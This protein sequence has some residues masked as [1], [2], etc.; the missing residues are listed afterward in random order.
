METKNEQEWFHKFYE[1]TF[2]IQGWKSRMNEILKGVPP[3]ERESVRGLLAVLGE[4]IGREWARDNKVRRIDTL[5]LQ[6]WGEELQRAKKR[7]PE[8]LVHQIHKLNRDVD[9]LLA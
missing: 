8:E 9:Q 5:R 7:G 1:G 2:L 3:E 4:R 6:K